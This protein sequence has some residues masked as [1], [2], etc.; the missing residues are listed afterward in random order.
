MNENNTATAKTAGFDAANVTTGAMICPVCHK[1]FND[2]VTFAEHMTQHSKEEKRRREE[3]EK[4]RKAGQKKADYARL[5]KLRSMY[6]EAYN[7]YYKAKEKY[8]E[9]Y[10]ESFVEWDSVLGDIL[11]RDW[12][13]WF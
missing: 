3:E 13:R 12:G 5:E 11:K 2:V 7:A 1:T 8:Y 4:Q 6:E 9:D 10:N